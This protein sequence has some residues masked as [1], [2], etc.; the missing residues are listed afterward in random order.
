MFTP[1]SHPHPNTLDSHPP[2]THQLVLGE[3]TGVATAWDLLER[4]LNDTLDQ[5]ANQPCWQLAALEN[6]VRRF[7]H[8][9]NGGGGTRY[10][11]GCLPLWVDRCAAKGFM[12]PRVSLDELFTAFVS[13]FAPRF[14]CCCPIGS[15]GRGTTRHRATVA[16]AAPPAF[17]LHALLDAEHRAQWDAV[18]ADIKYGV[19][20][21]MMCGWMGEGE[22][23]L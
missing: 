2:L 3:S 13:I 12:Q 19:P 4:A 15:S 23:T 18:T 22:G 10:A 20:H 11:R 21:S 7:R 9:T 1:K 8:Q 5:A 6:G 17:V 16:I 14:F